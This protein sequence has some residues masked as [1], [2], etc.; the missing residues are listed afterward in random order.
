MPGERERALLGGTWARGGRLVRP[1]EDGVLGAGRAAE[2]GEGSGAAA[3][4]GRGRG[5]GR[6]R[7]GAGSLARSRSVAPSL[8]GRAAGWQRRGDPGPLKPGAPRLGPCSGPRPSP[9]PP[10]PAPAPGTPLSPPPPPAAR[11]P[12]PGAGERR[13]R[14]VGARCAP[15]GGPEDSRP[16]PQPPNRGP[17]SRIEP[18]NLTDAGEL[19]AA[20]PTLAP[21]GLGVLARDSPQSASPAGLQPNPASVTGQCWCLGF[22]RGEV[23]M[24]RPPGGV[25]N[26][27]EEEW[28]A[29]RCQPRDSPLGACMLPC[30]R[31][32][33]LTFRLCLFLVYVCQPR[34]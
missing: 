32:A 7:G 10:R 31:Q 25:Y 12:G 5:R 22:C 15:R 3:A 23:V 20:E 33:A 28:G 17:A 24:V 18:P 1:Q 9:G 2:P 21:L 16:P 11:G 26:P 29:P 19:P 14:L 13:A 8:G 34:R 4:G 6:G 27:E 30:T